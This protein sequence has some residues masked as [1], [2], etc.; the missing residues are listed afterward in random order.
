MTCTCVVINRMSIYIWDGNVNIDGWAVYPQYMHYEAAVW[1]SP[2]VSTIF[3]HF[4]PVRTETMGD[5]ETQPN[6]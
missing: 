5:L 6:L 2:F 1:R 3:L 4:V